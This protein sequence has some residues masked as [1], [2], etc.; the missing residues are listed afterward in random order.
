MDGF[1]NIE[2]LDITQPVVAKRL[3][4]VRKDIVYNCEQCGL[5]KN[6]Q[7]GKMDYQ[8]IGAKGILVVIDSPTIK[9]DRL[10]K[11]V[12]GEQ[13]RIITDMC[14]ATGLDYDK[15]I[16]VVPA[17]RCKHSAKNKATIPSCRM[18]LHKTVTELRPTA[19]IT[20]GSVALDVLLGDKIETG[21]IHRFDNYA[22]PFHGFQTIIYPTYGLKDIIYDTYNPVMLKKVEKQFLKAQYPKPYINYESLLDSSVTLLHTNSD[23]K[24]MLERMATKQLVAFDYETTGIQP[25]RTGHKIICMSVS[26]GVHSYCFM[27][28]PS[29]VPH[30]VSFLQSDV[31]KIA[32]NAKYEMI[33]SKALLGVDVAHVE[34]DT[35]LIAHSLNNNKNLVGLKFQGFV[36]FGI[37]QYEEDIKPLFKSNEDK[38]VHSFNMLYTMDKTGEIAI[39]ADKLMYYCAIDSL[40]TMWLYKEQQDQIQAVPHIQEGIDLFLDTMKAFVDIELQG[41]DVDSNKVAQ[42]IETINTTMA[43]LRDKIYNTTEVKQWEQSYPFNYSSNKDLTH[44]LY[45]VLKYPVYKQ[46]NTG[47]PSTDKEAL[48]KIIEHEGSEFLSL[49]IEYKKLDKMKGTYLLGIEKGVYDN[50]IHPSFN[51]HTVQSF[52]SSSS[53]PINFQNIPKHDALAKNMIRTV[54]VPKEGAFIEELDFSALEVNISQ[55][56]CQDKNL[57]VYLQDSD[58]HNMHTDS[59]CDLFLRTKDTMLKQERQ[60]T[61][62]GFVFSQIYGSNYKNCAKK[63]WEDMS[64]ESKEHLASK[65]YKTLEEYTAVVKEA[66]HQMWDIRFKEWGRWKK[67]NWKKYQANG[68]I[69]N[70]TGF[71]LQTLMSPMQAGNYAIQGSASHC[72]LYTMMYMHTMM[73]K[74]GLRSTIIGQIHDSI[75][76]NMYTDEVELVHTIAKKALDNLRDHWSWITLQLIMEY[77]QT[78]VNGDWSQLEEKGRIKSK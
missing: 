47:Q 28:K 42:N 74:I 51:L 34:A 70:Y 54:F 21:N 15:D 76:F 7:H 60:I 9:A 57:L 22:I 58:N 4:P 41:M 5:Y 45:D 72:L 75:V 59:A 18:L 44:L 14:N 63:L 62:S 78:P 69:D 30:I 29:T 71:R 66:E 10:G 48:E 33:W 38:G 67:D 50:V 23:I 16:W 55:C 13:R 65:G 77:E 26:D 25:Y 32:H 12:I 19:I 43:E 40:L 37:A 8:G 73:K 1:F 46:T 39:V 53:S 17:I 36:N 6:C 11:P 35:M 20:L 56:Y 49:L 3:P 64:K 27:V 61:K 2:E 31:P 68:Y 24:R 52:R